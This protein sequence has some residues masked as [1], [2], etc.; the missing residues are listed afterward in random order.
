M[1]EALAVDPVTDADGKMP[2]TGNFGLR[3]FRGRKEQRFGRNNVVLAAMDQENR[4][5]FAGGHALG[6]LIAMLRRRDKLAGIAED[7]GRR[8]RPPEPGVK[9]QHC[10][11]AEADQGQLAVV[12]SV[13]IEFGI[14][15]RV[16]NQARLA[17]ADP[18]FVGVAHGQTE[19]LAPARGLG[20]R[21]GRIR[22]DKYGAGQQIP[23]LLADG[24]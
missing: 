13:P 11:L 5:R 3:Q 21:L 10:P 22:G 15:K 14:E 4:R 17:D 6:D 19:P 18:A 7:A 23:P 2:L 8:P 20:A 1:D 24:D 12:Q 9:S 16:E